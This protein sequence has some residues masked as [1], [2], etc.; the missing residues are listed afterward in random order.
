MEPDLFVRRHTDFVLW[1]PR[2]T[3]PPPR[4]VIG[5]FTAGNPPG[6]A[7]RNEIP[8]LPDGD[9]WSIPATDCG[10]TDGTVYHYWFEIT[11]SCPYGHGGRLLRT[12][13]FATT[14]DWRLLSPRLAPPYHGD[15]RWPAAVLK[16]R[17]GELRTCD[18]DGAEPPPVRPGRNLPPNHRTVYYKLPTTWARRSAEGGVELAVGSFADVLALV[19]ADAAPVNLRGV[20]ALEPGRAHLRELGVTTL[21]LTPAADTWV[22]REWGYSTSH[23]TAPDHDLGLTGQSTSPAAQ[24]TLADLVNG[25]HDAGIR[26]G[27]DAVMAFAQRDPYR[28]INF[29]DFHVRH[30]AGDPEEQG[31]DGFGGDLFKYNFRTDGY[32]PVE[33]KEGPLRPARQFHKTAIAHWILQHGVDSIRIDSVNNVGSWD[34]IEQFTGYARSLHRQRTPDASED[35]F[36]VVGEELA[37]PVDLVRQNRLDALWNERFLYLLRSALLGRAEE[38]TGSFEETVRQMID[39]RRLGF[40]DGSQAVLYATSHDVQ[41]LHKERLFRFFNN[42]GVWQTEQRIKLAFVC[43]LTAVGIPMILAGEEFADDHD[44]PIRHPEKQTDPVN[45]DRLA[46]PWRRRV[47]DHVARLVRLRHEAEALSVN[48]TRFLH[49]DFTGGRRVLVWQRGRSA[50]TPVVVIANFSDWSQGPGDEYVVPGWPATPPGQRWREV[51]QDRVVPPEW[52]GREWLPRWAAMVY[53]LEP[54]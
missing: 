5:T 15:D 41:G 2:I 46:D 22:T 14:V 28:E 13:P 31:R 40:T 42:N 9:L 17:D 8:L 23:Y 47:F 49:T 1:R 39:C 51:T 6:L 37:V 18:P 33:G 16:W 36:L 10:L 29:L 7:G 43:L 27:Y 35:R 44:L 25:C 24:R 48:D 21:E 3:T 4:L 30:D 34:F 53:T 26:F 50:D 32:D 20:A 45:Y 12:D 54:A 52:A 38:Q 11:D 19:D